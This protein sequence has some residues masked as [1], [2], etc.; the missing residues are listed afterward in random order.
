M[1]G[2]TFRPARS[3]WAASSANGRSETGT[4]LA[5]ENG[6]RESLR[7]AR[8]HVQEVLDYCRLHSQE[9]DEQVMKSHIDL[10]VNDFSL[11]LGAEGLSAVRRLFS[12]AEDKNIFPP[13]ECRCLQESEV[14]SVCYNKLSNREGSR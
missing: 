6:I 4:L 14:S 1:V 5:V 13:S 3:R 12:E 8:Q 10:Y 2:A 9:M 7:Y 11:D